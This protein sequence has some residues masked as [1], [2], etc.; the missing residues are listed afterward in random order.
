MLFTIFAFKLFAVF[1]PNEKAGFRAQ[2]IDSNI[3]IGYGIALGDVDGDKKTDIILADK[4]QFVWYRNGDWKRF[5]MISDLTAQD[6]VCVTARD[7]DGDG[8]CEIAVGAQWNPAETKD[9]TKSGS[10]HF[11][12]R[13]QDPTQ[14]WKAVE[15]YHEPTIHRMRWV[16]SSNGSYYLAVLPLHGKENKAG[17]GVP[18]NMLLFKYPELINKSN[19]AYSINTN[20]HMTHNLE[21]SDRDGA[22]Q[23]RIYIGGRE[24][25][26]FIELDLNPSTAVKNFKLSGSI[27][28]GELRMERSGA[29]RGIIAAIEPMHGSNVV[30][31]LKGGSQRQVL[32]S[33][34]KEGHALAVA[35]ILGTGK[36]QV[37]AGWRLPDKDG[38]VG[39]KL[40]SRNGTGQWISQWIDENEMACEDLQVMD[41]NGDGKLDIIASGRATHN[42]KIYWNNE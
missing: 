17:E 10:V 32:D 2:T 3:S 25:I 30:V 18:V 22:S 40:Y 26:G 15:L 12:I 31:Y 27:G 35:D 21:I 29:D 39:I 33:N 16:K 20:M 13:P 28:V 36:E 19:P 37:V 38:K 8:K 41:L 5:V 24:G 11:L 1:L 42:L 14:L 23:K 9:E 7:L 4:K 34:F 6:N